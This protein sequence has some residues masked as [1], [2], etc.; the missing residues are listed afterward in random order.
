[1][2]WDVELRSR[3]TGKTMTLA[4]PFYKRGSN[5]R[6]ELGPDGKLHP[7]AEAEA[8]SSITFNYSKYYYDAGDDDVRFR[9]ETEKNA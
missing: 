8:D 4:N 9:M 2:G 3:K 1:M 5:V 7:V 6:A